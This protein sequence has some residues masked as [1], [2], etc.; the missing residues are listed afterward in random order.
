MTSTLKPLAIGDPVR[1]GQHSGIVIG[2]GSPGDPSTSIDLVYFD[3]SMHRRI[4]S[5][6]PHGDGPGRYLTE[7]E[8]E[9]GRPKTPLELLDAAR[10][11]GERVPEVNMIVHFAEQVSTNPHIFDIRKLRLVITNV[12]S[13]EKIDG[14]V[15]AD[16]NEDEPEAP[17][18]ILRRA[19]NVVHASLANFRATQTGY[20]GHWEYAGEGFIPD[21]FGPV[22]VI[23]VFPPHVCGA[24][25]CKAPCSQVFEVTYSNRRGVLPVSVCISCYEKI[26]ETMGVPIPDMEPTFRVTDRQSGPPQPLDLHAIEQ[27]LFGSVGA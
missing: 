19:N 9:A 27:N 11:R 21:R 12:Y 6:V 26:C 15:L 2:I 25:T 20:R 3:L 18:R 23:D 14:F 17:D 10:R 1:Y 8:I 4:E 16:R 7:V 22:K 24:S 5:N 13:L